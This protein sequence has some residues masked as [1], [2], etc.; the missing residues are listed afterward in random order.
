MGDVSEV[1]EIVL[2]C[3]GARRLAAGFPGWHVEQSGPLMRL[4]RA[5]ATPDQVHDA[6]VEIADLGLEL[7]SFHRLEPA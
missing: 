3:R 7:E 5:G 6:L 1:A 2:R 4:R